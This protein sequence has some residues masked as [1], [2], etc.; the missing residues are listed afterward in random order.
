[1]ETVAVE[2]RVDAGTGGVVAAL[3]TAGLDK[4]EDGK[5]QKNSRKRLDNQ[6]VH[7]VHWFEAIL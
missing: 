2:G 3:L 1:M 6:F 7:W 5:G 4:G